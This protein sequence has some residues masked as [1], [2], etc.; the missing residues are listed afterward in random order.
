MQTTKKDHI[1]RQA[2]SG[3]SIREYSEQH[4]I[5]VSK[6]Y[7]WLRAA[8][9]RSSGVSEEFVQ[10]SGGDG[11]EL[12]VEFKSGVKLKAPMMVDPALLFRLVEALNALHS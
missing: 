11:S 10:I 9:R 4:G 5:P 3:L 1:G 12:T 8:K 6:F 2:A 7:S